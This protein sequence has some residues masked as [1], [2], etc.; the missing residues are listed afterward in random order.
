MKSDAY[1]HPMCKGARATTKHIFWDCE[2]Y[3]VYRK[4]VLAAIEQKK[5]VL[6]KYNKFAL[7]EINQMLNDNCFK[8]T[9]VCPGDAQQLR[10][11]Y[12]LEQF[13]PFRLAVPI[14]SIFDGSDSENSICIG[15]HY[16][17]RV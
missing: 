8:N 1:D 4:K 7:K 3:A 6:K 2:K 17:H 16:Y 5:N 14:E 9:A 13:D 12:N 15:G 11:T 10:D